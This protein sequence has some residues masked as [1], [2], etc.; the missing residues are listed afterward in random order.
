MNPLYAAL[1][2]T[3]FETM[4]AL[5]RET[6][7]VNLGQGF[8]EDD[9]PVALREIA[10]RALIE[11]PNQYP[12][13]RGLPALR[14]AVATHYAAH[15]GVALDWTREVTVTSGATEALAAAFLALVAPGDE[16]IVFAPS[17]D[18]YAPMLRRAG[19]EV[20]AVPL[21]P[22]AWRIDRDA[23]AAAI[24]DRTR[25]IVVNTPH[26]PTG[27]LLHDDDARHLEMLCAARDIVLVADE[28]WEHVT[29]D[30]VAH[31]SLLSWPGL[32]ARCVK[33]GSA[34]KMFAMTGWKVGFVC[35]SAPL[36]EAIAKAHQF[37]T[38]T[39]PPN[40]QT[41]A[42]AGLALPNDYFTAMRA[43]LQRARD[44]LAHGLTQAGFRCLPAQGTYFLTVDLAA[45]GVA[46]PDAQFAFRA[47][48]EE[49]VAV[50]PLSAFYDS[51]PE[52]GFIRLCFAKRDDTL[53]RGVERL[54]QARKLFV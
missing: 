23:L 54:T 2:T 7:A 13:M 6:G 36:T 5:A 18:S 9:G 24:T 40:L 43:D 26:N 14:E 12:P 35:A 19:A 46:A 31:K 33:I 49:G 4:S 10:A 30:G 32:R 25:V 15:Q 20:R 22:P 52:T 1:P 51:A 17:Y 48:K 27:A 8:P 28:V 41:A 21:K 45:S 34:G 16:A 44:R 42:A 29:F 3:I 39:T 11:G 38:F 50:I 53:D 47:V 37:L